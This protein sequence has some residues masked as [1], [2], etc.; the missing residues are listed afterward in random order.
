VRH[1]LE[2]TARIRRLLGEGQPA[3]AASALAVE[4]P[5]DLR[6]VKFLCER[7]H[8]FD[9]LKWRGGG[10]V[11]GGGSGARPIG[12][13]AALPHHPHL[14]RLGCRPQLHL[15]DEVPQQP[16]PIA[17]RRGV[18][19][20]HLL[21]VLAE[22]LRSLTLGVGQ[23]PQQGIDCGL[24][25]L[26]ETQG[27]GDSVPKRV[28]PESA[29]DSGQQPSGPEERALKRL[30]QFMAQRSAKLTSRDEGS[31]KPELPEPPSAS[32]NRKKRTSKRSRKK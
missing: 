13:G 24:R 29:G 23:G 27:A 31:N 17:R 11:P 19:G 28:K 7:P 30:K 12:E 1:V 21:E 8:Q 14:I 6:I 2:R 25:S 15:L 16:F 4:D 26:L 9:G 32:A 18:R 10:A 20:L 3:A 5:R 22:L